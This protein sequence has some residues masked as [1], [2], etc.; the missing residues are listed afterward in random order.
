[1]GL[2]AVAGAW[3]LGNLASDREEYAAFTIAV[4]AVAVVSTLAALWLQ[5]QLAQ[6]HP[7]SFSRS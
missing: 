5:Q 4:G 6:G 1:M 7:G 2:M 3:A